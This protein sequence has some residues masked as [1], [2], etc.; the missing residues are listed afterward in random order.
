MKK[1]IAVLAI[2]LVT[3][4][5]FAV[6][7]PE[8]LEVG[9][10]FIGP[11]SRLYGLKTGLDN[12]AMALRIRTPGRVAQQRAAEVDQMIERDNS[13]AAERASQSLERTVERGQERDNE[14]IE[15]AMNAFE[16]SM[17]KMEQR[18]EEAPTDEA[19][20]GMEG[21]LQNMRNARQNMEEAMQRRR[22]AGIPDEGD[23]PGEN[24]VDT[25]EPDEGPDLPEETGETPEERMDEARNLM[26]QGRTSLSEGDEFLGEDD[27]SQALEK[28]E[29]AERKFLEA[30]NKVE[31]VEDAETLREH[32]DISA[33]GSRHMKESMEAFKD[34]DQVEALEKAEQAHQKFEEID[35]EG[36]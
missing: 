8:N 25:P 11:E 18:I 26:E 3:V 5:G 36:M 30:K 32:L 34:G 7:Q 24:D 2:F 22:E 17:N 21:A 31:G 19:R 23:A 1:L 15:R 35:V 16:E 14:G 12:V 27:F 10:G 28:F 9:P 33:E 4:T 20:E 13:E 6:A 29:E